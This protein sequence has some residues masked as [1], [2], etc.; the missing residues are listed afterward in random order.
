LFIVYKSPLD[1]VST[2][3][4]SHEFVVPGLQNKYHV[5]ST[6]QYVSDT[7]LDKASASKT[8]HKRIRISVSKPPIVGA[9][10]STDTLALSAIMSFWN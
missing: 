1:S 10:R 5:R 2:P 6:V 7:D 9:P 3:G 8:W 4:S